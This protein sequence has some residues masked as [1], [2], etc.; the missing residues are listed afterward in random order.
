MKIEPL[1]NTT[2]PR[3][4]SDQTV[5]V[6]PHFLHEIDVPADLDADAALVWQDNCGRLTKAMFDVI[7][8][9]PDGIEQLPGATDGSSLLVEQGGSRWALAPAVQV[10][11]L[12]EYQDATLDYD[13]ASVVHWHG[14]Y[15]CIRVEEIEQTRT[16]IIS[17]VQ[18]GD[19]STWPVRRCPGKPRT[20]RSCADPH[21][22]TLPCPFGNPSPPPWRLA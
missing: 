18:S 2:R 7:E 17:R 21:H 1:V 19:S 4:P 5:A 12:R 10:V 3:G 14:Q 16:V 6:T 11:R 22:R 9:R 8:L 20:L 15:F 13:L